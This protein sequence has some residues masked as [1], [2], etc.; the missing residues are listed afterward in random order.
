MLNTCYTC[1]VLLKFKYSQ[2]VFEERLDVK[3]HENLN[4]GSRGF[5]CGRTDRHTD[6]AKLTVAYRSFRTRPQNG[7]YKNYVEYLLSKY[8]WVTKY[9]LEKSHTQ[10]QFL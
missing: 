9:R 4:C 7:K 8:V 5:R 10:V 6:M 2:Q 1:Q 3:F